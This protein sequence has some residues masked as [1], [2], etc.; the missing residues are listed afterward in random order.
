MFTMGGSVR[1]ETVTFGHFRQKGGATRRSSACQR[2]C[3]IMRN[4]TAFVSVLALA[5]VLGVAAPGPARAHGFGAGQPGWGY[6]SGMMGMSCPMMGMMGHG[7]MGPSMM[8]HGMM[9]QSQMPMMGPGMMGEGQ[10][11]QGMGPGMMQS[12]AKDLSAAD[13]QHMLE[14]Q[15]AWQGNPN[16]KLGKVEETNA[17]TIVA[18]VVTKD[19]SLVQKFEVNRHTGWMRP[20]QQ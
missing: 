9:G 16:L 1:L 8:G 20:V 17:D 19:G 14:H 11:G 4:S 7:M 15:L 5:A 6:G 12:L 13:V 10:M 18:E 3:A 2:R